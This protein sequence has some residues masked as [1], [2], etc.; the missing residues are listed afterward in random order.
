MILITKQTDLEMIVDNDIKPKI[1]DLLQYY[2][3]E[4]STFCAEG[5][6]LPLGAIIVLEDNNDWNMLSGYGITLPNNS[7]DF[8]WINTFSDGYKNG[9][10][11]IDNDRALNIIGKDEFF[12]RF[13][14]GQIND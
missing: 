2:L 12:Q 6:I 14:G 1:N 10:I 11:V 5:T 3:K 4:Y 7:D 8:E 9:C 13:Y